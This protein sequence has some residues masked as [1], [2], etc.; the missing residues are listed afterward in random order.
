MSSTQPVALIAA[1]PTGRR[2]LIGMT[3][4]STEG[5]TEVNLGV[6]RF[7][8]ATAGSMCHQRP[9]DNLLPVAAGLGVNVEQTNAVSSF[10]SAVFTT[11]AAQ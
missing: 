2:L 8:F 4:A 9:L 3:C 5:A 1:P 6:D 10:V 11:G 7:D